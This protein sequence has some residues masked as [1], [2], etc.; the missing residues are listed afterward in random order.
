MQ[1]Y[2]C[3]ANKIPRCNLTFSRVH[4]KEYLTF[5]FLSLLNAWD[6]VKTNKE[7]A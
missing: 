7:E 5:F 2:F 6:K 3:A 1:S 4:V